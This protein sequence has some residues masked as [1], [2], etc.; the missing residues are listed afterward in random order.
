SNTALEAKLLFP[1]TNS[2]L[3]P[4]PT[5]RRPL[6]ATVLDHLNVPVWVSTV[7]ELV[8]VPPAL[9]SVPPLLNFRMTPAFVMFQKLHSLVV[10]DTSA[11]PVMRPFAKFVS[12]TGTPPNLNGIW[13]TR[14][15]AVQFTVPAL[16]SVAPWFASNCFVVPLVSFST[17][18]AATVSGPLS[19]P[20]VHV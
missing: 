10:S 2:I 11:E 4:L 17:P 5:V 15:P 13:L 16:T 9:S 12:V 14:S 19:S 20:L 7:P 8:R 1:F 3:A 6:L 18:P